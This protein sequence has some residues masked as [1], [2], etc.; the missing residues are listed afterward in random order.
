MNNMDIKQLSQS[1]NPV[2]NCEMVFQAGEGAGKSGS[3]FFFSY[4]RKFII[5][6]MKSGELSTFFR[7]IKDYVLHF[8]KNPNSLLAKIL[9]VFTVEK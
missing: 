5:K 1:L 9:G 3:F 7:F 6:T 8:K 2:L 4:D